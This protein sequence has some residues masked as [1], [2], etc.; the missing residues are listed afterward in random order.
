MP[1][2]KPAVP[3]PAV[4]EPAP[5]A[6]SPRP[7]AAPTLIYVNPY[8]PVPPIGISADHEELTPGLQRTSLFGNVLVTGGKE[9]SLSADS[10]T[11]DMV[12]G[13]AEARGSV[14]LRELDTRLTAQSL[15]FN[16]DQN[17]GLAEMVI[18]S[19]Y[20]LT[21]A[22]QRIRARPGR[23]DA[24][25][26]RVTTCPPGMGAPDYYLRARSI[27]INEQKRV[28]VF[29]RVAVV[30]LGRRLFEV[31][32]YS[33]SFGHN[34]S[35]PAGPVGVQQSFGYDGYNGPYTTFVARTGAGGT[36]GEASLLLPRRHTYQAALRGYALLF[37]GPHRS[38]PT[39]PVKPNILTA[40]RQAAEAA[41]PP[42]PD[43]D[44]L[45]FHNFL[46]RGPFYELFNQPGNQY[47][48]SATAAATYRERN[49][50]RR[51]GDVFVS[52]L[53]EVGLYSYI[54]L[55]GRQDLPDNRDPVAVRQAL[56]RFVWRAS[57]NPTFGRY[58]EQ[59]SN[60]D[61]NRTA[62][63]VN[64]ETRPLLIADNTLFRPRVT[65]FSATYPNPN[66]SYR[67]VQYS[68]AVGKDYSPLTGVGLEYLASHESGNS[69]FDFDTP[70]VAQELDV[71]GQYGDRH[72]VLGALLK[73]DLKQGGL[74]QEQFLFGRILHCLVPKIT[75]SPRTGN[76]GLGLEIEGL[77][78]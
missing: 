34:P 20:H 16:R 4:P 51:I 2:G 65:L 54:P 28:I 19:Q 8:A 6:V 24:T 40:I 71:R 18:L 50:G 45:L 11:G 21:T 39:P 58:K 66:Q 38:E 12:S 69:P 60:I 72:V 3:N 7:S 25:N 36:G 41:D 43:G 27:T 32:R 52:R 29:R 74:F 62:L 46:D 63:M 49:F 73:Y 76:I 33:L 47:T 14:D 59:P 31:G 64:L 57:I 30:V 13:I 67:Y 10:V 15:F 55:G 44:P 1:P 61:R 22:A 77:T 68:L 53:P 26:A 56:R 35:G 42:L 78:F 17:V 37:S 9:F 48:V 5:T 70:N 75:Y 23:I